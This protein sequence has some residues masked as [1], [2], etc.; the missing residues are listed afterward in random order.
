MVAPGGFGK[1]TLLAE[2][3]HDVLERGVGVAWLTLH[4][5]DEPDMLDTYLACAFEEAGLDVVESL[6]QGNVEADSQYLRTSMVL[7]AIEVL[8][9]PVVLALDEAERLTDPG[10]VALINFL[11]RAAPP[12]LHIAISGR[13]L[14]AGL[15][16][17]A[18]VLGSN[19]EILTADNLRFTK[20]D[21]DGFFNHKLS[22]GELAEVV[23]I[24]AGWPI[25]LRIRHNESLAATTAESRVVR[26]VIENWVESRLWY[27]F[28]QD[29]EAFL[30]DVGLFEWFDADLLN[31]VT[32]EPGAMKRLEAMRA[33]DGLLD[34]VG[35]GS[36]EIWQLH[37]LIR[38]HCARRRSLETPE[39]YRRIHVNIARVLARRG[40]TVAAMA[41]AANA[42]DVALLARILLDV[43]GVRMIFSIGVDLLVAADRVIPDEAIA[44]Y[45]RLVPVRCVA[46]AVAGRLTEARRVLASIEGDAPE[47]AAAVDVQ[48]FLDRSV[49]MAAIAFL[50]C[51]SDLSEDLVAMKMQVLRIAGMPGFDPLVRRGFEMWQCIE[52][53]VHASFDQAMDYG[54]GLR[55]Q[56]EGYLPSLTASIDL[57][58]GQIAMA[59]GRVEDA[60]HWYQQ[61]HRLSVKSFLH[62]PEFVLL[63]KLFQSE[64]EL[65][66]NLLGADRIDEN[67]HWGRNGGCQLGAHFAAS[68]IALELTRATRGVAPALALLDQR[69]ESAMQMGLPALKRHLAALEVSLLADAGRVD[70]ARMAWTVGAF[71]KTDE[72]CF[73][74]VRQSW[75][76]AEAVSCARLRLLIALGD[77]DAGRRLALAV[78]DV[79]SKRKLKRTVMRVQV[80]CLRLE[81]LA[82]EEAATV[83]HL[84]TFLDLLAE[85]DY[86]RALVQEGTIAAAVIERFLKNAASDSPYL[87]QA[88]RL[89]ETLQAVST[90]A[91]PQLSDRELEVLR[92]LEQD[93]DDDIAAALGISRHGVRYHI[94]N[95]FVK[96]RV[97]KRREAVQLAR[98]L[99]L[100]SPRG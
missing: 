63:G 11:V 2:C 57:Q 7:R 17:S 76:E 54:H 20:K 22:P 34:R 56:V 55:R 78:L 73:D 45:P 79:A 29:D 84:M 94:G 75:R 82:G 32:E 8:G 89:L 47:T 52:L 10:L 88:F 72:D 33:L 40:Q 87:D 18:S 69:R 61:A 100:L 67:L 74:L 35:E 99:G 51:E 65:E 19:A 95:I 9:K 58:L 96:L 36:S 93:R 1:T 26:D 66:R 23:S 50:G 43:G 83:E 42:G 25:A 86:S 70:E 21:I 92:R 71:P 39:R 28:V 98:E 31:E 97:R 44:R 37:P 81:Q 53:N 46:L 49:A 64:L 4:E 24:S 77:F 6:R 15:D 60:F 62:A 91:F 38:G 5:N 16:V 14:P 68:D 12:D 85:T 80:L 3:C 27:S 30:L 59:Q 13:E 41:H 90:V 48:L